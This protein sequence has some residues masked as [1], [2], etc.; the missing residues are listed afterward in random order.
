MANP[1]KKQLEIVRVFNAPR[2]LVWKMWTDLEYFKKW[3]GPKNFTCP[4]ASID[5]RVGG[6]Y[7]NCMQAPDGKNY[8][9]TGVYREIVPME[10]I[11]YTD[12]FADEK[13]NV[14]PATHYGMGGSFPLEMLVTVTFE[15]VGDK[16]KMTLIHSELE[17]IDPKMLADM[18][19]GWNQSFDKM[20]SV[21]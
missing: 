17:G 11:V 2:D 12:S 9:S 3:W 4:S 19:L 5:L 7:L 10:K 21:L 20:A 15:D 13:G 1:N 14:V 8:W 18:D 16:T 6:K